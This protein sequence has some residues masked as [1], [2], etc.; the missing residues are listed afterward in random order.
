MKKYKAEI[1]QF[2]GRLPYVQVDFDGLQLDKD[3][4][5]TSL[6]D[7]TGVDHVNLNERGVDKYRALVYP[8]TYC[9]SLEELLTSINDILNRL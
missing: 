4:V 5:Q 7:V 2:D 3:L 6:S 1:I 8:T 9:N